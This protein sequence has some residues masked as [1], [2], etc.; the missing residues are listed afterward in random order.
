MPTRH[1]KRQID[2]ITFAESETKTLPLP[3][4]RHIRSILLKFTG[5]LTLSG[6]TTSGTV[7]QDSVARLFDEIEV[8]A[9][10]NDVFFRQDGRGMYL[11][12]RAVY[13]TSPTVTPPADGSA[14]AN[15]I[16]AYMLIDFQNVWGMKNVDTLLPARDYVNSLTL[17]V[18]FGTLASMFSA[19]NDRTKAMTNCKVT[20]FVFETNSPQVISHERRQNFVDKVVTATD[21]NFTMDL[22]P[23]DPR[24]YQ[25]LAFRTMDA[26][27]RESDIINTISLVGS[28]SQWPVRRF[29]FDALQGLN[30]L[31][32]SLESVDAGFA[33]LPL[34]E[35]KMGR[36]GFDVGSET[37]A[38]LEM[39]VTVGTGT[40]TIRMYTDEL[41]Q[42]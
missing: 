39:D 2:S 1:G 7:S 33:Y 37:T 8:R 19:T 38:K 20:P 30:K 18:R 23:N 31:E 40:T 3:T 27:V 28:S 11:L 12:N 34:L 22:V 13:K 9:G 29:D 41:R 15:A 21:P 16:N 42:R 6:G 32:S 14:T 35:D 26:G 25:L 36:S 24:V 10:G 17:S 5:T 4:D